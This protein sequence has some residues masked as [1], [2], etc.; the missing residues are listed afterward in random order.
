[1]VV[2]GDESLRHG[3]VLAANQL[4]KKVYS[5]KTGEALFKVRQRCPELVVV[6]PNHKLYLRFAK[7]TREIYNDYTDQV[8]PFG[9]DESFLDVTGSAGLFG[10][11]KMIADEIRERI[12][13]ELGIT[14]SIGV[15]Y[16]KSFA[17]LASDMRKPDYTTLI[18]RSEFKQKVWPLPAGDLIYVGAASRE[19]LRLH[20]VHTIGDLALS[21]RL[22][23]IRW[24]G[25]KNGG[26]LWD[27]ANGLD[28]SAVR[29]F[30]ECMGDDSGMKSVGHSTTTPRDLLSAEDMKV[31]VMVL[32]EAVA[33]RLREYKRLCRTVSLWLRDGRMHSF[34][35]QCS[36][37]HS[38]N[39]AYEIAHSAMKLYR[40]R[41][42]D[43]PVPIRSVGVRASNL[44]MEEEHLQLSFLPDEY[45]RQNM[46]SIE[47]T[48]DEIRGRYGHAAIARGMMVADRVLG[49]DNPKDD[50]LHT[51]PTG[52]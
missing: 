50:H 52:R 41:C 19:K 9:L 21:E 20:G 42:G 45:K 1:V 12:K 15:S 38:T 17:K 3:I 32:S 47:R 23:V 26:V 37:S 7:F 11:G 14:V 5:V 8:E 28:T 34:E 22:N 39:L 29:K 2:G 46:I 40:A 25:S 44:I 27:Y 51:F 30:E 16:T 4:A 6:P 24:T 10:D 36:T 33:A 18:R 43:P 35:S 31:T 49:S 13:R 48:M